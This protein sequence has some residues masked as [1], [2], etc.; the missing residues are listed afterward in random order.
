MVEVDSQYC[1]FSRGPASRANDIVDFRPADYL[2]ACFEE[3]K[4]RKRFPIIRGTA[5]NAKLSVQS[6]QKVFIKAT[7]DIAPG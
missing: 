3:Y 2:N 7:R 6:K 5:H 1:L 4:T